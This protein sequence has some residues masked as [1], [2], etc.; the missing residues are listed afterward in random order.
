MGDRLKIL[1]GFSLPIAYCPFFYF[2][3]AAFG[4]AAPGLGAPGLDPGLGGA[5]ALSSLTET[6]SISKTRPAFGPILGPAPR[7][8]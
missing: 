5:E 3:G 1:K 4:V 6:N 2:V 7:S 8:P